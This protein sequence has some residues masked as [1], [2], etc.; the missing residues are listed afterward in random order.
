MK[1]I[2]LIALLLLLPALASGQV[3]FP[4]GVW[5]C[6]LADLAAVLTECQAAATSPDY[7]VVTQLIVQTT[8]S[9]SG[10]YAVRTGTGTNCVTGTAGLFP[11][12]TSATFKAPIT[13]NPTAVINFNPPLQAPVG[14]AICVFGTGTNL[15]NIQLIGYTNR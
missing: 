4:R 2:G 12:A 1:R 13:T 15:I 9:T 10:A 14:A 5:T 11:S 3:Q 7:Y 6:S 8:T